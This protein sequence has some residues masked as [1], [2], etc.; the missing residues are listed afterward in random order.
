VIPAMTNAVRVAITNN[1]VIN[2][3]TGTAFVP[4]DKKEKHRRNR[5]KNNVSKVIAKNYLF[6]FE[7]TQA[8]PFISIDENRQTKPASM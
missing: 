7:I 5:I 2:N 6:K 4:V 3:V 8:M 1:D